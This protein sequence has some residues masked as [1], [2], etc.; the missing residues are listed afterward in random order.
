MPHQYCTCLP[1]CHLLNAASLI[2]LAY[3]VPLVLR[4]PSLLAV[5]PKLPQL[6]SLKHNNTITTRFTTPSHTTMAP[7]K[8][9]CQILFL[10]DALVCIMTLFR[11][12]AHVFLPSL[13]QFELHTDSRQSIRLR[14]PEEQFTIFSYLHSMFRQLLTKLLYRYRPGGPA[15]S[16]LTKETATHHRVNR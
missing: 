13:S 8:P 14:R 4:S 3:K 12:H 10:L 16:P 6:H 15:P 1:Q 2:R 5:L 7:S 11:R 9:Y